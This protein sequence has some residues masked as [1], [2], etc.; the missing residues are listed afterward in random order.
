MFRKTVQ[1]ALNLI[2][3][4]FYI[5]KIF[6]SV[7]Q[8][9][10]PTLVVADEYEERLSNCFVALYEIQILIWPQDKNEEGESFFHQNF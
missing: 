3:L 1:Y 4:F 5:R 6:E 8:S 10:W 2:Q 9:E 7:P